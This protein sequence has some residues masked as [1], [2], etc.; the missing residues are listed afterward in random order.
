MSFETEIKDMLIKHEGLVCN[1]YKCSEGKLTIGVGRNLEA[2]GVSEDEALYML[3]NDIERVIESLDKSFKM[4]RCM[5]K[6]ARM[7]CID[8]TFQMGITGF[9]GFRKTIALM[10]MGMW[11][12][13]SEEVLD[14]RYARQT[15]NRC[16]YNSRQLALCHGEKIKR[17]TSK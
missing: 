14:S 17:G 11:L 10:Q 3:D 4:W 15:P 5:P 9:L 8:M 13:A 6:R 7:V 1:T 16:A 12:E 2:N